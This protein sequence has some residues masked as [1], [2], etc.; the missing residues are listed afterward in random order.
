MQFEPKD[1]ELENNYGDTNYAKDIL[2]LFGTFL[3][4][5]VVLYAISG[6][7]I[8][9]FIDSLSLENEAKVSK[10]FSSIEAKTEQSEDEQKYQRVLNQ[11]VA[12]SNQSHKNFILKIKSGKIV[13]AFAHM[14]QE[15]SIYDYVI[16]N[17][18]TENEVA[19]ILAHELGH[20]HHRH[21]LKALGRV[22]IL[23]SISTMLL[24]VDS[25]ITE[26]VFNT[27][28]MVQMTFSRQQETDCDLYGLELLNKR[29]GN[30]TGATGFLTQIEKDSSDLESAV[31]YFSTH[32]HPKERKALIEKVIEERGYLYQKP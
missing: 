21:H 11:L 5:V 3:G 16:D 26:A 17:S 1:T 27:V 22:G 25:E 15:I 13:N 12:A 28:Q 20:Y 7:T 6:F 24:G 18:K 19:M 32:P 14:N 29:Y 2:L 30:V 8:D 23:L 4:L 10:L 9:Y 31:Q